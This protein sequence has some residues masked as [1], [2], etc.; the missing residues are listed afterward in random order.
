MGFEQ[1]KEEVW[2]ANIDLVEAGLVVHTWGNVSGADR[3][4]GVMAIKPSGVD[5]DELRHFRDRF[6]VP[7][8]GAGYAPDGLPKYVRMKKVLVRKKLPAFDV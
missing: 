8:T 4:E 7:V 3:G 6:D 5:Y 1:L 2:R